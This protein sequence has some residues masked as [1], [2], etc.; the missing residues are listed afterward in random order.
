MEKRRL[1]NLVILLLV[2][3]ACIQT[4]RL[5]LG[6]E[7]G[8]AFFYFLEDVFDQNYSEGPESSV[9]APSRIVTG[10]GNKRFAAVSHGEDTLELEAM[11]YSLLEELTQNGSFAVSE[12]ADWQAYLEGRVLVLEYPFAVSMS[13]YLKGFS[14][15][16]QALSSRVDTF[17]TL[18]ILPTR[19][20][21]GESRVYFLSAD[22]A[23]GFTLPSSEA[24]ESLY[25]AL[26][27]FTPANRL[28]YISAKQNGLY[29]FPDD[30]FLPQWQAGTWEYA[31]VEKVNPFVADAGGDMTAPLEGFFDNMSTTTRHLDSD[32]GAYV[33]SD[34]DRVVKYYPAGVLEYYNYESVKESEQTL[35]TA[36][37]TAIA[38]LAGKD[39]SLNSNFLLVDVELKSDGLTFYFDYTVNGLPLYLSE[40][41]KDDLGLSHAL[42]VVVQNNVVRKYKKLAYYFSLS[43]DETDTVETDFLWAL[44][45]TVAAFAPEET[46]TQVQD[47]GLGYLADTDGRCYLKWF[48]SLDD[49]QVLQDI[50]KPETEKPVTETTEVGAGMTET[51][52][53]AGPEE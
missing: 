31:V 28:S 13:E 51:D 40:N 35:A 6:D 8:R 39:V 34:S 10:A 27:R 1:K 15:R 44:D 38:F 11:V 37:T 20:G 46:T 30:A 21:E 41:L 24:T 48:V 33:V 18:V 12:T 52:P 36:Y 45:E 42:E 2:F 5:W 29:L 26:G 50:K 4:G 23:V 32:S 43:E 49:Q 16:G 22:L 25:E 3:S 19:L 7:A 47:I 53:A 9:I 14:G 17:E